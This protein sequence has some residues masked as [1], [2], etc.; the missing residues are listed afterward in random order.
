[1]LVS[2]PDT[3]IYDFDSEG[4]VWKPAGVSGPLFVIHRLDQPYFSLM[5]ASVNS[6]DVR[7]MP[8]TGAV[9]VKHTPPYI[10]LYR[11]DGECID[12]VTACWTC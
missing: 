9:R 10:Y 8:L 11:P 1:V 5:V 2:S 3:A 6:L 4:K 12:W 7:V